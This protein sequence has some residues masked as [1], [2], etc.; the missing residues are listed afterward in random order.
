MLIKSK[1]I[2]TSTWTS[3]DG[4]KREWCGLACRSESKRAYRI[5]HTPRYTIY[6]QRQRA[7]RCLMERWRRIDGNPCRARSPD[8]WHGVRA[9]RGCDCD[10]D[11][12]CVSGSARFS[13]CVCV[14]V[15]V[16][17]SVHNAPSK[18]QQQQQEQR[19][20]L[21]EWVFVR[22]ARRRMPAKCNCAPGRKI[23][24]FAIAL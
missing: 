20:Q 16:C 24:R 22:V 9:L 4:G 23:K 6:L 2:T 8:W 19:K 3:R 11:C 5:T 15:C 13:V 1:L 18:W 21:I 14:C 12:D 17:V 10:W 7:E